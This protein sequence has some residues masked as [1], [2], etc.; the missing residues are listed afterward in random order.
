MP[1]LLFHDPYTYEFV[2]SGGIS[3]CIMFYLSY[4]AKKFLRLQRNHIIHLTAVHPARLQEHH[5]KYYIYFLLIR[6][7]TSPAGVIF[8]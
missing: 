8:R 1:K 5:C 6:Q 7:I 2:Y 3:P 4:K